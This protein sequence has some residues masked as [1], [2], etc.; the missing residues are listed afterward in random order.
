MCCVRNIRSIFGI[1]IINLL[2]TIWEA[3]NAMSSQ[4]GS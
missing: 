4:T 2:V 1:V 3:E